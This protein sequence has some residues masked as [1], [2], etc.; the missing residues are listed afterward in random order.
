MGNKLVI[1]SMP[2]SGSGF[3]YTMLNS[4]PDIVVHGELF[5][6]RNIG[7]LSGKLKREKRK[8]IDWLNF[9]Y[10]EKFPVDF[11]EKAIF[12]DEKVKYSGFKIF[13]PQ[14]EEILRHVIKEGEYRKIVL[15]RDNVLATYSS[16]RTAQ[17]SG[18]GKVRKGDKINRVKIDF[19]I[20]DFELFRARREKYFNWA[21]K[22]LEEADADFFDIEYTELIGSN[23]FQEI[24]KFLGVNNE[25]ELESEVVKRNPSNIIERFNNK[26]DVI[27]YMEQIGK[28]EWIGN[29][30][31]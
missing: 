5:K 29:E 17:A 9:E 27:N 28:Y 3:L 10:R 7:A 12:Y 1:L 21:Y 22:L 24:M 16:A 26:K 8:N 13:F 2:R 11:M 14:N 31:N 20:S 23:K 18:Q 19:S 6:P 15:R 30:F 25:I 4:H